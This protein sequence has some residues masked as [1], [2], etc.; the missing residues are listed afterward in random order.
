M[1]YKIRKIK[2]GIYVGFCSIAMLLLF[3]TVAS[4]LYTLLSRGLSAINI[5]IFT[6]MTPPLGSNIPGGLLN[7]IYGSFIMTFI[8]VLI[9]TP[10]GIFTAIYLTEFNRHSRFSQ[11]VRFINDILL[12]A[13]SIII[14]LFVY[15][16]VVTRFGYSALAGAISIAIIALPII[17]RTSEDML[18]IVP[19][20]LREAARALGAPYW[21]TIIRIVIPSIYHGIITGVLLAIARILGETA[22]LL[23]TTL[24]N[25]RWSAS[26]LHSI[27]SL[28]IVIYKYAMSP[29]QSAQ[30]LA[31]GGALII[32]MGVAIVTIISR[33][34][35]KQNR[36]R[37]K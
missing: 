34:I 31:W 10:I 1:Q 18:A 36:K 29:Y 27:A 17:T 5:D 4:L 19:D 6:K 11:A 9:A 20:S 24:N 2:N 23:F 33:V 25:N 28:P 12:S 21:R 8:A 7:A 37:N 32:T 15:A 3:L 26:L 13:P 30:N 14:G 22:P 35:S 16:L